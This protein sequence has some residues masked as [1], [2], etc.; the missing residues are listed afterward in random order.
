MEK[1]SF[2]TSVT[3]V[4][5][6]NETF[7]VWNAPFGRKDKSMLLVT[8][9]GGKP[10]AHPL[11]NNVHA[12]DSDGKI[13][14]PSVLE[15]AGNVVL[16]ELRG[17]GFAGNFLYVVNANKTQNSLLCYQ[18]T[19]TS[20]R[21][22]GSFV[23]QQTCKGVLHPF[24]FTFDAAGHC[25]LSSQDTN[26]VTRLTV[27]ADG[28]VGNPAPLAAALPASGTFLPGTFVASS[29]ANLC[30]RQTTAVPSPL[31]LSYSAEGPK[32]HSVRG[33][34][35][36]NGALYVVDQPSGCVKV[37]DR[38]GRLLGQSNQIETPVHLLIHDGSLFVTGANEVFTAK[39][40]NPPGNF[41]LSAIQGLRV[42]NGCGMAFTNEGNVYIGSRTENVVLKF[43]SSYKPLKFRCELPD[44]PEFLLHV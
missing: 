1:N 23:S 41:T 18:G 32:T 44:N 12:Y 43:D 36:A 33:V 14:T 9:H 8:L 3:L 38:E 20:Y 31:G 22:V 34:A 35:F 5:G 26:L 21:F 13:I 39:L 17:I 7:P 24:D 15:D 19:G 29:V 25:Y 40:S 16:D 11:R 2:H 42:K 37:Y 10:G 30:G 4:A 27:S 6:R 28:E